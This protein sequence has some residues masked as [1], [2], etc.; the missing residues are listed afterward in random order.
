MADDDCDGIAHGSCNFV[1]LTCMRAILIERRS[2][3]PLQAR[4]LRLAY[5][6]ASKAQRRAGAFAMNT[7]SYCDE[8]ASGALRYRP[9]A[10]STFGHGRSWPPSDLAAAVA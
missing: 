3:H 1:T 2:W 10:L 4:W 8:E 6:G 9:T 5:K 7:T